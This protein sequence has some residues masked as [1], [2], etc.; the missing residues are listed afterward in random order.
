MLF[1]KLQPY[2]LSGSREK[3]DCCCLAIFSSLNFICLKPCSLVMLHVE[4]E[5]H[6][7]SDLKE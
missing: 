3:V 6:G 2:M 5:N 1:T 4:F 7:C